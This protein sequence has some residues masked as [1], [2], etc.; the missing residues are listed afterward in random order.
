LL[1]MFIPNEAGR[2]LADLFRKEIPAKQITTL[3]I[4][5]VYR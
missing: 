3:T 2:F 5:L 4:L 1:T